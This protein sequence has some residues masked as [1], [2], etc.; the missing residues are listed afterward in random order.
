MVR[1]TIVRLTATGGLRLQRVPLRL[2]TATSTRV[3]VA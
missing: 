1:S 3:T 2:S